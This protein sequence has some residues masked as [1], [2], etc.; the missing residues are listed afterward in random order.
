MSP[1][2]SAPPLELPSRSWESIVSPPAGSVPSTDVVLRTTLSAQVVQLQDCLVRVESFLK[3]AE[4]A[5]SRI[6]HLPA[7]L[8]TIPSSHSPGEVDVGSV[9]DGEAELYGC[10]SPRV[11]GSSSSLSTLSSIPSS[12]EVDVNAAL[13]TPVL[14]IMPDLEELC[15]RPG[16]RLSVEHMKVDSPTL[17]SPEQSDVV[18]TP[19][20]PRPVHNSD[21][22]LAK[23]V[24]DLLSGLE[25]AIPGCGRAF[26]C[27]LTGTTSKRKRKVG[28]CTRTSARKERS[29]RCKDQ[30]S[31]AIGKVL[32]TA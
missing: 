29:L 23:E 2:G 4:V 21:D 15:A 1:V 6:S 25:A 8:K 22:L 26:A 11:G 7:M 27:L 24:C 10:Y 30:K 14:Q 19:I 9:E 16:L 20:P 12:T 5:L 3:W 13:M 32:A 31:G 18:S 28:D 17:T